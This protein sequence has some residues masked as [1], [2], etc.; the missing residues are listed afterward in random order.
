MK[1][2]I[3]LLVA[4]VAAFAAAQAPPGPNAAAGRR[5]FVTNC[6]FCHGAD[7]HG[8]AEGGPDLTASPVITSGRT[9]Q[10]LA[11]VLKTGKPPKMPPFTQ[12]TAEQVAQLDA[13]LRQQAAAAQRDR[14]QQAI[15]IGNARAGEAYF[16]GAGGCTKCHSVAGDLK[17]IGAKYTPEKLQG[18]MML[19]RGSGGWPSN[20]VPGKPNGAGD[21]YRQATVTTD[22]GDQFSGNILYISDYYI[23]VENAAGLRRTFAR[24]GDAPRVA[25]TDPLQAHLDQLATISPTDMHNLTA[26][27]ETLK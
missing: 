24:H 1:S 25:I 19:P 8:G 11:A 2:R 18:R 4:A 12:L 26:Y 5:I 15:L 22:S 16:N 9:G 3:F 7:A 27:L 10:Q 14:A 13:Y 23:T 20:A 17:G 6:S 21:V